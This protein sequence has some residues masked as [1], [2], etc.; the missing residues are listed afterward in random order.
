MKT[1]YFLLL[2]LAITFAACNN[3][4]SAAEATEDASENALEGM[5]EGLNSGSNAAAEMGNDAAGT[6]NYFNETITAVQ[7]VGG[8]LT[9]I[10]AAT[11]V[12]NIDGWIQRLEGTPGTGEIVN[13]LKDLKEELTDADG[14]DGKKVGTLLNAL[15]E[16]VNELNNPTLSP[17]ANALNMAG[18]KLG[19]M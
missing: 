7:G 9:A 12:S 2:G 18:Q 17:L 11:A 15:G 13:N 3:D 4:K 10:P 19:G 8:D 6:L 16:D 5:E 14:I 1:P